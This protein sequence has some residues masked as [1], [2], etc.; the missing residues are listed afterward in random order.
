MDQSKNEKI[1]Q[2][3]RK[4][5]PNDKSL[6]DEVREA[7]E[8]FVQEKVKTEA[9]FDPKQGG[10]YVV[11]IEP[12]T[13]EEVAWDTLINALIEREKVVEIDLRESPEGV[14]SI[15]DD[16]LSNQ[17]ADPNRWNWVNLKERWKDFPHV[18]L[19]EV[20]SHVIGPDRVLAIIQGKFVED[21]YLVCLLNTSDYVQIEKLLSEISCGKIEKVADMTNPRG[22][23]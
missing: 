1:L 5:A 11:E 16:L 4:L 20:Q 22:I 15:I 12:A 8:N 14:A 23:H 9:G 6:E 18:F 17:P 21:N 19:K 3:A 13:A 2:L 7:L 10:Y